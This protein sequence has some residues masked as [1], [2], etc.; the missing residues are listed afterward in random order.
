MLITTNVKYKEEQMKVFTRRLFVNL[1]LGLLFSSASNAVLHSE[2]FTYDDPHHAKNLH[3]SLAGTNWK[4]RDAQ[5][6]DIPFYQGLFND[7]VV[8]AKYGNG[9]VYEPNVTEEFMR[10][11]WIHRFQEGHPH[12]ALTIFDPESPEP[13]P[14]GYIVAGVEGFPGVSEISGAGLHDYWRQGIGS[15]VM[16]TLLETWAPEVRRIGLGSGLDEQDINIINA[17]KCFKG[18]ELERF[19]ATASPSNPGSWRIMEKF[20]F[21]PAAF[22][23]LQIDPVLD[24]DNLEFETPLALESHIVNFFEENSLEPGVRYRMVDTNGT[25]RTFSKH[26]DF[27]LIKYHFERKVE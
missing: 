2:I 1:S 24:L 14:I 11:R 12:G 13:K 20:E 15:E 7:P 21:Q 17:F 8:M 16:G 6:S 19:D 4:A 22:K 18:K 27:Q 3:V 9:Q 26:E 25:L 23:V 5:E 10:N